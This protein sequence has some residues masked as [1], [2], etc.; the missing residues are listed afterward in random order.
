MSQ[1]AY[2]ALHSLAHLGWNVHM[3]GVAIYLQTLDLAHFLSTNLVNT[4]IVNAMIY[5]LA[6]HVCLAS[7]LQDNIY[8]ADLAVL[9]SL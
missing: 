2:D 7:A 8:I 1:F 6:E 4:N 5:I 9:H 3:C